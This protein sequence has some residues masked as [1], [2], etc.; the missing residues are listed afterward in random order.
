MLSRIK[1]QIHLTARRAAFWSA[2]LSAVAIGAVLATMAG[3]AA[4]AEAGIP[5]SLRLLIA[6]C[7]WFGISGL[8]AVAASV[9]SSNSKAI[10]QQPSVP[11]ASHLTDAFVAGFAEG[12]S[13]GK[14]MRR[15]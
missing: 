7:I 15:M 6:S 8:F 1:T 3:L 10:K 9:K 13:S 11:A 5:D 2:A 12:A 4:L 14:Q